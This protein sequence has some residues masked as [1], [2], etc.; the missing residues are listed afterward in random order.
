MASA[1]NNRR[2]RRSRGRFGILFKFLC[3]LTLVV[4]VTMGATVFFRV[5]TVAVSG[6]S[7]Y[8]EEEVVAATGIQ[9]DDNLFHMNKYQISQQ[10]LQALPYVKELTIRRSLP[11]TIVITVTEWDAVAQLAAPPAGTVVSGTEGENPPEVADEAWL[12]SVGGKLL[13]PAPANS[14]KPVVSGLTPLMPKAGTKVAVP[15]EEQSKLD[16]LLSLLAN[17]EELGMM[18]GVSDIELTDTQVRLRYLD[19]FQVK[20]PLNGDFSYQLRVLEK[21]VEETTR[22][23]GEQSTGTMDLTQRDYELVY[24]PG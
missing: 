9:V 10:V 20:L 5:E 6:N 11:S 3:V 4:A 7:R 16:G 13:E 19:R 23:H 15:Q 1:R 8:T 18:E 24:S 22:R 14:G 17:L 2:H 12:I 21:G